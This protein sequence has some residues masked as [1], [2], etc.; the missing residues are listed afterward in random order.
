MHNN[1]SKNKL[2][3]VS[4]VAFVTV[5]FTSCLS[6]PKY[7]DRHEQL[8]KDTQNSMCYMRYSFRCIHI[9]D[10][11]YAAD[12]YDV[13]PFSE[14]PKL[15]FEKEMKSCEAGLLSIKKSIRS[16]EDSSL[17]QLVYQRVFI[18]TDSICWTPP[19]LKYD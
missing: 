4:M 7:D 2:F 15:S 3:F 14:R 17:Q 6:D 19:D 11:I 1:F 16:I 9:L 12:G 18:H 5:N 13:V 10:S 8:K